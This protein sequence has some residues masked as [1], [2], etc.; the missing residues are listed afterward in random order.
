MKIYHRIKIL[1]RWSN[2]YVSFF[3]TTIFIIKNF[4]RKFKK[5][6]FLHKIQCSLIIAFRS[7]DDNLSNLIENKIVESA[8]FDNGSNKT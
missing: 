3:Y 2:P 8:R 7:I 5:R 1:L 4:Q 6:I